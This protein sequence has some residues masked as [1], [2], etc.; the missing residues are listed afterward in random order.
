MRRCLTLSSGYIGLMDKK[1]E[2]TIGALG[3]RA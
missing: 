3:F 2:V 1:F